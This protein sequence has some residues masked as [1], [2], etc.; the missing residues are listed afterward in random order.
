MP[1]YRF[2]VH[3]VGLGSEKHGAAVL[4]DDDE[5]RGFAQR[6]IRELV[7]SDAI[8]ASGAVEITTGKRNV[9]R[10]T[11]ESALNAPGA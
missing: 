11:F 2:K 7:R 8:Y 4:A 3:D 10:I 6:V 1:S 9:A 5:A